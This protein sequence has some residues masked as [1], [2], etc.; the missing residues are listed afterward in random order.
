MNDYQ[1]R[2]NVSFFFISIEVS[3]IA[4]HEKNILNGGSFGKKNNINFSPFFDDQ[5]T[6]KKMIRVFYRLNQAFKCLIQIYLL[7]QK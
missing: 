7:V 6:R 5:T 1:L 3:Y 2:I 4:C